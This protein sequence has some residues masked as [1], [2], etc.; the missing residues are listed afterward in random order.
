[1]E[2]D[3]WQVRLRAARS[4]GRLRDA[5]ALPVLIEALAHRAGNLRKEAAIALGEVGDTR[6]L[7]A[8]SAA[9]ADPDPEVR[10]ASRLAV[11]RLS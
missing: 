6:A 5:E 2:D 3:Y 4:L 9:S 8:L 11:Q 10:K 1:M 7:A